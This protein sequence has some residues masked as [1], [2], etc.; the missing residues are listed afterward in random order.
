MVLLEQPITIDLGNNNGWTLNA[1]TTADLYWVGG[2]GNWSQ[3]IHW[4]TTSGERHQGCIPTAVDHVFFDA[5]SFLPR[6]R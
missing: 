3:G 1:K 2:T 4:A 6:V 5:N